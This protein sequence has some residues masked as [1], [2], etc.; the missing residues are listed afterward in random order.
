MRQISTQALKYIE[1]LLYE[2]NLIDDALGN[3]ITDECFLDSFVNFNLFVSFNY[4][5]Y[6]LTVYN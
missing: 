2:L 1:L 4:A 3:L 6:C 5:R